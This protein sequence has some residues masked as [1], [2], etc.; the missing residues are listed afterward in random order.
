VINP[1]GTFTRLKRMFRG[2]ADD[3]REAAFL[4]AAPL[5]LPF[6]IIVCGID[7]LYAHREALVSHPL[8]IPDPE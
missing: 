1:A 8:S 5:Q 3:I 4:T 6:R 2:P 7:E